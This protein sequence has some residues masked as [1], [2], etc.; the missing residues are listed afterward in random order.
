[1]RKV[2]FLKRCQNDTIGHAP[3]VS[4][5][6][7]M[8]PGVLPVSIIA[9]TSQNRHLGTDSA[10]VRGQQMSDRRE[11]SQSEESGVEMS[12][13]LGHELRFK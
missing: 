4:L 10:Q 6:P 8:G 1:M 2:T 5:C 7:K 12:D 3:H 13:I 9:A 11:F